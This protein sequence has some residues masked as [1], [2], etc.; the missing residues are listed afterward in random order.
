MEKQIFLFR[1][2]GP[3]TDHDE[4]IVYLNDL[5]KKV[6]KYLTFPRKKKVLKIYNIA[7]DFPQHN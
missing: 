6:I 1:N 2:T 5:F 3:K 4:S 7:F